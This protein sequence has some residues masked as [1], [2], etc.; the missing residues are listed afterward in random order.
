MDGTS[1]RIEKLG[2]REGVASGLRV[3]RRGTPQ[4]WNWGVEQRE[5]CS[6]SGWERKE[7]GQ[8]KPGSGA[9]QGLPLTPGM[10]GPSK[11]FLIFFSPPVRSH[12]KVSGP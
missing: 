12:L 11:V 2:H 9:P 8:Q 3:S 5:V 7:W 4:K 1:P 10:G 6:V